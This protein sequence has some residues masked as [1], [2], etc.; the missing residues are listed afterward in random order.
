MEVDSDE[1]VHMTSFR[2]DLTEMTGKLRTHEMEKI[3]VTKNGRP[4]L[5]VVT[6]EEYDRLKGKSG[7]GQRR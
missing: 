7:S 1:L 5:V 2:R 6:P 4:Q 3:V